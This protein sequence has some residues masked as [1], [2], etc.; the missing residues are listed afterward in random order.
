MNG[1]TRIRTNFRVLNLFLC[2]RK[3]YGK[4]VHVLIVN[5]KENFFLPHLFFYFL[6]FSCLALIV[7]GEVLAVKDL[8]DKFLSYM[9]LGMVAIFLFAIS[10]LISSTPFTALLISV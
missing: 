1:H 7:N 5:C 3:C 6:T 9:S 2:R 4:E 10:Y 8:F